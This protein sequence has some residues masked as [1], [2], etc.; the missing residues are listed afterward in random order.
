[1]NCQLA[2]ERIVTAAYGDLSDEQGHE[3]EQHMAGCPQC[4]EEREQ[5]RALKVVAG[6]YPVLEPDANLIVRAR[7]R[8][9]A[10]NC[11]AGWRSG[12]IRPLCARPPCR[13]R[14]RGA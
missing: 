3:L 14:R 5:L 2:Q 6:A 11:W 10:R 1:M 12:P 4:A 9:A 8:P 7:L 13:S